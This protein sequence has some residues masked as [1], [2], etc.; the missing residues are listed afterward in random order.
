MASEARS[1][2]IFCR[3]PLSYTSPNCYDDDYESDEDD[4]RNRIYDDPPVHRSCC[5]IAVTVAGDRG[6]EFLAKICNR[7]FRYDLFP[8][9]DIIADS[10]SCP[11]QISSGLAVALVRKINRFWQFDL[12]EEICLLVGRGLI[13]DQLHECSPLPTLW[14]LYSDVKEDHNLSTVLRNVKSLLAWKMTELS[15]SL[16]SVLPRHVCLIQ[17]SELREWNTSSPRVRHIAT[18]MVEG[19]SKRIVFHFN[20]ALGQKYLVGMTING[21]SLGYKGALDSDVTL[22]CH[23]E[24]KGILLPFNQWG[25]QEGRILDGSIPDVVATLPRTPTAFVVFCGL[26]DWTAVFATFDVNV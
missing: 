9:F 17:S 4:W 7:Y 11:N 8:L 18:I 25:F 15:G 19:L 1:S 3:S 2:C 16:L 23:Q 10:A 20:L 22:E 12:P 21:R 5:A 13:H 6:K 24:S 14:H 26:E